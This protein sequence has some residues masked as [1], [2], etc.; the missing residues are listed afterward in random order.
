MNREQAKGKLK[1]IKELAERGIGGERETALRM[2]EELKAKY[3]VPDEEITEETLK[4]RWFPYRTDQEEELLIRCFYKVTGSAECYHYT[5]AKKRRKKRGCECTEI[6]AA[7][8]RLLYDFYR[9]ELQ[10]EIDA[11]ALA[12]YCKAGLFPD[13]TARR[14]AESEETDDYREY[15]EEEKRRRYTAE[16]YVMFMNVKAPPRA[17]IGEWMEDEE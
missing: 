1:K 4:V 14:Y 12:F 9:G 15:T 13:K 2:Y 10:K 17:Q 6:E 16:K 7:E 5:G 11:C 3:D 8:I